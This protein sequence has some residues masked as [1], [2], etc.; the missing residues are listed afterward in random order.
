MAPS[1][2]SLTVS[3]VVPEGQAAKAIG[4]LV[5]EE[6]REAFNFVPG[7]YLT[8]K[9]E[10][11]GKEVRRSYS[12]CSAPGDRELRVGIKKVDGGLFSTFAQMLAEGDRIEVMPPEGRFTA[13]RKSVV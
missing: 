10:I 1:F 3:S 2:H 13:D 12:I 4:F 9:T 6:L 5:P 11:D 8:L 7:Q